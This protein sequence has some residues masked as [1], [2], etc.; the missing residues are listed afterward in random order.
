MIIN[1]N[2]THLI[3]LVGFSETPYPENMEMV[4]IYAAF[5]KGFQTGFKVEV[6]GSV[7]YPHLKY[8]TISEYLDTLL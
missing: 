5:V 6:E 1:I 4:F 2:F 8:T 7:L 3:K